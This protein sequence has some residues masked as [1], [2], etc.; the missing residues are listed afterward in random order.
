MLGPFQDVHHPM[1][2]ARPQVQG[3]GPEG[4]DPEVNTAQ[5]DRVDPEVDLITSLLRLMLQWRMKVADLEC[6][7][8]QL[9]LL[10]VRI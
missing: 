3:Q 6:L 4:H 10:L 1:C 8:V 2:P 9:L 5:E 7:S